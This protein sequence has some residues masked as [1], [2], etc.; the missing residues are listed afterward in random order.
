MAKTTTSAQRVKPETEA[1][2]RAD[3]F[4]CVAAKAALGQGHMTIIQAGDI[5]DDRSDRLIVKAISDFCPTIRGDDFSSI[6]VVFPQS[7]YMSEMNFETYLWARLQA[8]HE[9]DRHLSVWDKSVSPDPG[10][11]DFAMSLGGHGFFIVGMHPQASRLARRAPFATLAFNPHA[12]FRQLRASGAYG[13]L[14]RAMRHRDM[15]LQGTTNPMLSDHGIVSE[16]AQYSGRAVT[17]SWV[18][19]FRAGRAKGHH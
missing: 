8:F 4:V 2:I 10:S 18:C 9:I 15:D 19:P 6:L 17:N 16:A 14:R 7:G 5:A 12:Q 3:R 1:F 11:A 13:R